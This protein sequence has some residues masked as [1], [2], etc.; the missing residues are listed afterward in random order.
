MTRPRSIKYFDRTD[1]SVVSEVAEKGDLDGASDVLAVDL[2]GVNVTFWNRKGEPNYVLQGVDLQVRAGE[3]LALVG[4]SGC[5]KTTVL[6]L[7]A[8]LERPSDGTVEV[9]GQTPETG[10]QSTA[11]MFARD[12]L[13][14]W[15]SAQRNVELGLEMRGVPR[16][17]R[18][19]Q[20][21]RQL[22]QLGLSGSEHLHPWRLSQG[23]RQ[24]VAL[25][26]TWVLAPRLILMDE[27]FAALDAQ[28]RL[29][30]QQGFLTSWTASRRTVV[31][32]THDLGEAI[33]MADRIAVVA[34]GKIVDQFPV[35]LSR[36][37]RAELITQ[38]PEFAELQ[39]RIIGHLHLT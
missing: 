32:V 8:G 35:Q 33:M 18:R 24:R 2:R 16:N 11:Y 7:L 31:F 15:R 20:A 19:Q 10:Q 22:A 23:M 6:N 28:T 5:G 26:R 25:A 21:R 4:R 37:R 13:L 39:R 12:A 1:G 3:F 17:E 36:P 38:E 14:P 29:A 9:F 30:A 27:P 34:D